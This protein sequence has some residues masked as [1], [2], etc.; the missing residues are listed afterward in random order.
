M[1]FCIIT[2]TYNAESLI[3]RTMDNVASQSW[4]A[5]HHIII[6]GASTDKTIETAKQTAERYKGKVEYTI[7]SEPD[8]GL[9]YAMN[10]G[11]QHATPDYVLF[12]NA[13]D[14]LHSE[15]TLEEIGEQ[16]QNEA[17]NPP[18]QLVGLPEQELSPLPGVIYGDTDIVDVTNHFVGKR[19][20]NPPEKLTWKSFQDGMLVCHQAFY[21]RTDIAQRV[22]FDTQYRFSADVDWCIRVMKEVEK[23]GL[24]LRN[25]H[26]VL[27]DFLA[28]GLT[29]KN[30]RAS[31]HERFRIMTKHYGLL[32]TLRKHLGFLFGKRK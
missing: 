17:L 3:Q 7:V 21:V 6:D 25:M 5:I 13:G 14:T 27:C 23:E 15:K 9:Y 4:E 16:F 10:K 1:K 19:E 31:L 29:I 30:H 12:L 32:L 28:G 20:H 18:L 11:L 24:E 26:R 2:C 22:A 8:K